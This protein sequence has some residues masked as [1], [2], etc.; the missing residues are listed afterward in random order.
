MDDRPLFDASAIINLCSRKK[1]DKV[2]DGCTLNLALYEL[3]CRVDAGVPTQDANAGG[4]KHGVRGLDG[5][6]GETEE[7]T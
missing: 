3:K 4:G 2:L 6:Y 7:G 5:R 1:F